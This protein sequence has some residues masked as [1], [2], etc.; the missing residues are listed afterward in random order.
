MTGVDYIFIRII[1]I[2]I[3]SLFSLAVLY[4][5]CL[6]VFKKGKKRVIIYFALIYLTIGTGFLINMVQVLVRMDQI[7]YYTNA[8]AILCIALWGPLFNLLFLRQYY[9]RIENRELSSKIDLELFVFFTVIMTAAIFYPDAI[10]IDV[11]TAN[12]PIWSFE[13]SIFAMIITGLLTTM[14]LILSI[15]INSKMEDYIKHKWKYYIAGM[16]LGHLII[17]GIELINWLNEPNI[18][19]MWIFISLPSNITMSILLYYGAFK[20]QQ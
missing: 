4:F 1:T 8:L 12:L 20:Y 3:L 5:F 2:S 6:K 11:E 7:I 18:R 16:V 10:Y 14:S 13:F 17:I 9:A 15:K 19:I